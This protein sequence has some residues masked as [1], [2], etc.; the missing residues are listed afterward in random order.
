MTEVLHGPTGP[1][2][3]VLEIGP[4]V[5]ALILH[6]PAEL[7]GHEIEISPTGIL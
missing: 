6:T 3:V 2:T 7:N 4:G 1:G 5:G